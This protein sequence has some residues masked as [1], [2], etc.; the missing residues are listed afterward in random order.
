MTVLLYT[1]HT[2]VYVMCILD[3]RR[4]HLD[5]SMDSR[6]S[7]VSFLASF[8]AERGKEDKGNSDLQVDINAQNS[9]H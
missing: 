3:Y 8:G 4:S 2:C 9:Q 1:H 6:R 5:D 7:S